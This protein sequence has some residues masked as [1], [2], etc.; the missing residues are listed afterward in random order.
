MFPEEI[1]V[2]SSIEE[3]SGFDLVVLVTA[4]QV[5]LDINWSSLASRMNKPII[6]DGRRVLDISALEKMGWIVHAVGRPV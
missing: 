5:C 3:A 6:F 4:H 1:Q 2:I